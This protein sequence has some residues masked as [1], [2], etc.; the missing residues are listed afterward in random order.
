L[1]EKAKKMWVMRQYTAIA[2]CWNSRK[3]VKFPDINLFPRLKETGLLQ[4]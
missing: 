3:T 2:R 1:G 4:L